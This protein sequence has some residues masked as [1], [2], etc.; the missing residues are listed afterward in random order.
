MLDFKEEL[1]KYKPILSVDEIEESVSGDDVKDIM[2][3]LTHLI[4]Q[5]VSL[6]PSRPV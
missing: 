5:I 3:L 4:K 2:D 6:R 1:S